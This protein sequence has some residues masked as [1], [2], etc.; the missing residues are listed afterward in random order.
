MH[1]KYLLETHRVMQSLHVGTQIDPYK[2]AQLDKLTI[3]T[4]QGR[5]CFLR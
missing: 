2:D 3:I 5:G 4:G 1:E